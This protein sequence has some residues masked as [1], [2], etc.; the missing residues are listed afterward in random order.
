MIVPNLHPL[1]LIH[2]YRPIYCK[3]CVGPA[4]YRVVCCRAVEI[5]SVRIVLIPAV[6]TVRPRP[7][8][9][10]TASSAIFPEVRERGMVAIRGV[11]TQKSVVMPNAAAGPL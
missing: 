1:I 6:R 11:S 7:L 5:Q 3:C 4:D 10:L 2:S 8:I 9:Y